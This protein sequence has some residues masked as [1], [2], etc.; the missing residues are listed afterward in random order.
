MPRRPPRM[1]GASP[2]LLA[3]VERLERSRNYLWPGA[4]WLALD[5]WTAWVRSPS[6]KCWMDQTP[7][8][9]EYYPEE[10]PFRAREVLGAV[11]CAL[12]RKSAREL[13]KRLKELDDLF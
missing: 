6:R 1:S 9:W 11:A 13:R 7:W 2:R 8:E 5:V 3:D 4:V 10:D 12:P